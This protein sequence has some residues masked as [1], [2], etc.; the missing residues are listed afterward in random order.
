MP[1]SPVVNGI[2]FD[3]IVCVCARIVWVL[4]LVLSFCDSFSQ[5]NDIQVET[6]CTHS[7]GRCCTKATAE[8]GCRKKGQIDIF[9]PF[10]L[11]FLFC[12]TCL[13]VSNDSFFLSF[14]LCC[15][16]VCNA[17]CVCVYNAYMGHMHYTIDTQN[18]L[19]LQFRRTNKHKYHVQP[20][21]WPT[22]KIIKKLLSSF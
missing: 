17:H 18:N 11:F 15:C 21:E 7:L 20:T 13:C 14:L 19:V 22:C 1:T 2:V 6:H 9:N 8:N 12:C 10:M 5:V 3:G 16:I 4:F